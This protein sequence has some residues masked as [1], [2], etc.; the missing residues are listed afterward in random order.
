MADR[1]LKVIPEGDIFRD[2]FEGYTGLVFSDLEKGE[3]MF[4]VTSKFSRTVLALLFLNFAGTPPAAFGQSSDDGT[5]DQPTRKKK[6]KKKKKKNS[7]GTEPGAEDGSTPDEKVEETE[8]PKS[9]PAVAPT[10]PA[11]S[12]WFPDWPAEKF[13]WILQPIFAFKYTQGVNETTGA[14]KNTTVEGGAAAGLRG[15]PLVS[16]NPGFTTGPKVGA[17]YGYSNSVA[18]DANGDNKSSGYHYRRQWAGLDNTLYFKSFRYS[19]D[20][21]RGRLNVVENE[22]LLIQSFR[23]DNDFGLLFR[24]WWSGHYS[25]AHARAYHG[26]FG[27]PFLV[28]NDHWVHTRIFTDFASFVFDFGPGFTKVD[29]WDFGGDNKEGSGTVNYFLLK[30]QFNPF[31]KLVGEGIGKY[32][33]NASE[34]RLGLYATARLP[35]EDLNEPSTLAM[36]EDSFLG[37]MFFG[38]KDLFFGIG[39]GWRYNMQVLN[40]AEKGDTKRE[41]TKNHGIGLY[42]EIRL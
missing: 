2:K 4:S 35:E 27:S 3:R 14:T 12:A 9:A 29:A 34:K 30:T 28:E 22:D 25:L 42:Y 38:V 20:L 16:G 6:S 18:K 31:W 8:T 41:T 39:V 21:T 36:P 26:K 32:A 5:T 33:I 24:S 13:D 23:A 17:A 19:L 15:I 40:V 7:G 1:A 37:S 11:S 10:L